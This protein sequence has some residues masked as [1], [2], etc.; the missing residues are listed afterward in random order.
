MCTNFGTFG[1]TADAN[2]TTSN[3]ATTVTNFFNSSA[4][5]GEAIRVNGTDFGTP[6]TEV[7]LGDFADR[8]QWDFLFDDNEANVTSINFWLMQDIDGGGGDPF[9]G[10]MGMGQEELGSGSYIWIGGRSVGGDINMIVEENS[11]NRIFT[12]NNAI[13]VPDDNEFHMVTIIMDKQ[14]VTSTVKYC[15]DGSS[16]CTTINRAS[17]WSNAIS[18]TAVQDLTIGEIDCANIG[19]SGCNNTYLQMDDLAIW[20]EYQL[21]DEDIDNIFNMSLMAQPA[22]VF[23]QTITDTVTATDGGAQDGADIA[24]ANLVLYH[25]FD[26]QDK[27]NNGLSTLNL[28][29]LGSDADA[30]YFIPNDNLTATAIVTNTTGLI[31]ESIFQDGDVDGIDRAEVRLGTDADRSQWNFL[32]QPNV[33]FNQTSINFW[34]N[35][36]VVGGADYPILDSVTST[37]PVGTTLT[38][39]TIFTQSGSTNVRMYNDDVLPFADNFV[40]QE[41]P[42]DGQWHMIT[43]TMDKGNTTGTWGLICID[44][45]SNCDTLDLGTKVFGTPMT[46]NSTLS[47]GSRNDAEGNLVENKFNI[48]DLAI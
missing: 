40:G 23:N 3:R 35:G 22:Q 45:S 29:T 18:Q 8:S 7:H 32:H 15:V 5:I 48:D 16:N 1:S 13:G 34:I 27:F 36:D 42:D 37:V 47:L 31:N 19:A 10:T 6:L 26:T 38:G 46:A 44:G 12:V 14:N 9:Y 20:K 30:Q 11:I 17:A 33:G 43:V 2:H 41:P 28:G 4:V 25:R 39:F 24:L 21:T